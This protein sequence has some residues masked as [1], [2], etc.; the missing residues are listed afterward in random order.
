[1]KLLLIALLLVATPLANATDRKKQFSVGAGA[2]L[3]MEAPWAEV[4][5]SRAVG[6]GPKA[7]LLARYHDPSSYAG[8][9][10]SMDYLRFTEK[11]LSS[12]SLIMSFFWRFLPYSKLH[13]LASIGFGASDVNDFFRNGDGTQPIIKSKLG[14]EWEMTQTMDLAFHLDHFYINKDHFLDP[15]LHILS[16]SLTFIYYFSAPAGPAPVV[17]AQNSNLDSDEDGVTDDLDRCKGTKRGLPVNSIGCTNTQ[18]FE[19]TLDVKFHSGTAEL[20]S[21]H[22]KALADLAAILEQESALRVELQGHTDSSGSK[23]KNIRLSQARAEAVRQQ[24]IQKYDIEAS[25]L[26]A[27]GYGQSQPVDTNNNLSGR[28]N[29]R[30]VTAKVLSR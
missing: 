22:S 16:P 25:R 3:A 21:V 30:R 12:H 29:N 18:T 1:M 6:W 19:I 2:G 11:N 7:S 8:F 15:N 24:L 13:P 10:L 17:V 20:T 28:H 9:E 4:A 23:A 14:I 5:F 26:V 27:K